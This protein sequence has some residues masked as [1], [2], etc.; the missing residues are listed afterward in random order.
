NTGR[1]SSSLSE[2]GTGGNLQNIEEGLRS[3]FIADKG[4]KLANFDAE[5]GE[6]RIVGAIEWNLFHNGKYLDACESEDVH[7]T[8]AHMCGL[9]PAA[10]Q[11]C[12]VLGHGTN[13]GGKPD[14][15][16]LHTGILRDVII[17]F[18]QKYFKAFPAHQMWHAWVEEQ[19]RHRGQLISLMGRKR[20]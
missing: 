17:N 11:M 4:M 1:F 18:Q 10:R 15:M 20:H 3:I 14:T 13:Y 9:G 19:V 16:A 8:V 6:S 5:Q 12:K 2:F 7:L